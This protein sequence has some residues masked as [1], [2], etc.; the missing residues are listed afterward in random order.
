M[1]TQNI[2][3]SFSALGGLCIDIVFAG[4]HYC[5]LGKLQWPTLNSSMTYVHFLFG[6]N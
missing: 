3:D 1:A 5:V 2:I 4:Y 6:S